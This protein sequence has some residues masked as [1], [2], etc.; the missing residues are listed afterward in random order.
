MLSHSDVSRLLMMKLIG[1]GVEV[2]VFG[3]EMESR[4]AI[5]GGQE[6]WMESVNKLWS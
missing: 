4:A 1:L 5:Q 6:S 2:M 3:N